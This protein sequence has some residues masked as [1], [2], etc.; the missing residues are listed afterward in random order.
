MKNN[1][2]KV[3]FKYIG[4]KTWM[5]EIIRVEIKKIC[6]KNNFIF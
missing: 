4:G 5:K 2:A 1:E 3:L 6:I